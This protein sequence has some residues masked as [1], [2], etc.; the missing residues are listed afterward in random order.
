[1]NGSPIFTYFFGLGDQEGIYEGLRWGYKSSDIEFYP[2]QWMF[3]ANAGE[4]GVVGNGFT[5]NS[6]EFKEFY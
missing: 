5:V 4:F 3:V 2:N 1:M 6:N